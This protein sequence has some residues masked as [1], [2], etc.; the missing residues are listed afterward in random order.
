MILHSPQRKKTVMDP[1]KTFAKVQHLIVDG[2]AF[3][4][5]A[6]NDYFEE[7]FRLLGNIFD[8]M[9]NGGKAPNIPDHTYIALGNGGP[10]SYTL[11]AHPKGATFIRWEFCK[12]T[13]QM[14][15]VHRF[16]CPT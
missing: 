16:E 9:Q 12:K 6:W 15:E 4:G 5:G 14:E 8:H 11:L 3:R 2:N 10:V 13:G 7:A 1:N